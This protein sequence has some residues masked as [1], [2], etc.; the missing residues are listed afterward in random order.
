M[1]KAKMAVVVV[2]AL[3]CCGFFPQEASACEMC[4]NVGFVCNADSC[5]DVW[6]CTSPRPVR[7]G[8]SDCWV[9]WYGCYEAGDWC[10]WAQS[11]VPETL[12]SVE[13]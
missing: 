1:P 7:A 8:R 9:T 3:L 5:E 2:I 12:A 6:L 10:L 11:Q 4:Q 13:R